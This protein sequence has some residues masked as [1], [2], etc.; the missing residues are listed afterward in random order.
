[1][2][3]RGRASTRGFTLVEALL[4]TALMGVILAALTTITSQWLP[5]WNRGFARVQ[6]A[7]TLA[8]G[9]E[10]IVADVAAAEFIS[11]SAAIRT[12]VFDGTVNL[13]EPLPDAMTLVSM[14]ARL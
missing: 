2:N 14:T 8:A 5:N 7:E 3:P 1:M 12:P 6:R 10:R 4:A 11:A 13:R 9:L